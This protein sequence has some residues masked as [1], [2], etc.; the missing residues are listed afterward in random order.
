MTAI[1]QS[2]LRK[3]NSHLQQYENWNGST[4]ITAISDKRMEIKKETYLFTQKGKDERITTLSL[5]PSNKTRSLNYRVWRNQ[6][7]LFK[8]RNK[9]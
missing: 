4:K 8:I 9:L 2:Q 3:L 1:K 5:L 6:A 7:F